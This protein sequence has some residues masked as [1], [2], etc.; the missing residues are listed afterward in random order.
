VSPSNTNKKEIVMSKVLNTAAA[1][2]MLGV[3]ATGAAHARGNFD[4]GM[5]ADRPGYVSSLPEGYQPQPMAAPQFANPG[6]QFSVPYTGN[7]VDQLSP[8]MG[9]G[10]P[11]ALGIK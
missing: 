9:A 1:I 2:I 11:D 7:A 4:R 8:L 5:E 6:P 3:T 10:Q